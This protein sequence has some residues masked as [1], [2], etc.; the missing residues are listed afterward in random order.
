MNKKIIKFIF[1]ILFV[2]LLAA[3]TI[4]PVAASYWMSVD[5]GEMYLYYIDTDANWLVFMGNQ[6][7]CPETD[8]KLK[9][10]Y[11]DGGQ[12]QGTGLLACDQI[13][14]FHAYSQSIDDY[15]VNWYTGQGTSPWYYM[16]DTRVYVYDY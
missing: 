5:P 16:F 1:T 7:G 15:Y 9:V 3:V 8:M 11:G 12:G 2:F 13:W 14:V 6:P 4:I 10:Y